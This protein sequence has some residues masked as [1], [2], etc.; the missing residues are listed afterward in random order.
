MSGETEG[1]EAFRA[2]AREWIRASLG[3]ATPD[4]TVGLRA[5]PADEEAR[6]RRA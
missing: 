5:I 2:R 6:R 4:S 3:L 1:V